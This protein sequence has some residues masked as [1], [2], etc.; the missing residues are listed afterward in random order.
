M[1]WG[2]GKVSARVGLGGTSKNSKGQNLLDDAHGFSAAL[3]AIIGLP[4]MRQ[5][6]LVEFTKTFF[7][8]EERPVTHEYTPLE[9]VFRRAIQPDDDGPGAPRHGADFTNER[10][11]A[12][13][14]ERAAAKRQNQSRIPLR[15]R[16]QN[17]RKA[18][19]FD[20]AEH[21]FAFLR[22]DL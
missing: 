7:I 18:F 11:V 17:A 9:K 1:T 21:R 13:L 4:V 5:A 22:K 19:V 15:R 8:A 10:G 14:R 2:S 12:R 16:S 6:F 20:L 3:D